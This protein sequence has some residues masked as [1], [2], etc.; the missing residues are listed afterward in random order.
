MEVTA[1]DRGTQFNAAFKVD[2]KPDAD[3]KL[4]L[5]EIK[6]IDPTNFL[7]AKVSGEADVKVNVTADLAKVKLPSIRSDFELNWQFEDVKSDDPSQSLQNFGTKLPT[8][9]LNNVQVGLGTF[10]EFAKPVLKEV[11]KFTEPIK[12]IVD[13]LNKKI[14]LKVVEPTLLDIAQ[15]FS[16]DF[17]QEDQDFIE[18]IRNLR[19]VIKNIPDSANSWLSLGSFDL[20]SQGQDIRGN[21]QKLNPE[22][23][24]RTNIFSLEQNLSDQPEEKVKTA[25]E[26]FIKSVNTSKGGLKF[27]ILEK[28][29][30]ALNLLFGK[31]DDVTLFT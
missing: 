26:T 23:L 13:I 10:F 17:S 1:K 29:E 21:G 5:D 3:K 8:V 30:L 11:E 20:G 2:L 27:P 7:E 14:P 22:N 4:S 16:K 6:S 19:N 15:L 28:P 24:K 18:S 25:E 31:G 9:A 12:P